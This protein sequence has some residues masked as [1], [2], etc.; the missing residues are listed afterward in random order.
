MMAIARGPQAFGGGMHAGFG[1]I[2]VAMGLL[3]F[4]AVATLLVV[5]IVLASRRSHGAGAGAY[6][7]APGPVPPADQ[8]VG[9]VRER[10]ARG[11]IDAEEY[12]R[13]VGALNGWPVPPTSS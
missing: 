13:L 4:F 1:G 11:E 2:G 5:L 3:F 9:I 10:L 7:R 8:A 6:G 12:N